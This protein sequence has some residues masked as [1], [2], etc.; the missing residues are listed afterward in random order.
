MFGNM[1]Q[2]KF[3]VTPFRDGKLDRRG[4][5]IKPRYKIASFHALPYHVSIVSEIGISANCAQREK[6]TSTPSDPPW[7]GKNFLPSLRAC[8]I[9][10]PAGA[11]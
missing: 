2:G 10:A 11:K 9:V 1:N 5:D 3:P 4:A 6:R 8:T 7:Q